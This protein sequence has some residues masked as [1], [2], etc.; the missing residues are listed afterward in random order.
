[1][2]A[3]LVFFSP[4]GTTRRVLESIAAGLGGIAGVLDMTLLFTDLVSSSGEAHLTGEDGG[5]SSPFL[6]VGPSMG[7]QFTKNARSV[8]PNTPKLRIGGDCSHQ[9][10][11]NP[12]PASPGA[13]P[14]R[15]KRE[16]VS[17]EPATF[18]PGLPVLVGAPVYAGRIPP[19]AAQRFLTLR[20]NDTPAIPVVVY[21]N[22]HYNDALLELADL[23]TSAGFVPVAGAA[24]IGE[25]PSPAQ[26]RPSRPEGLTSGTA[27]GPPSLAKRSDTNWPKYRMSGS[28]RLSNCPGIAPTS[29]SPEK[30][31]KPPRLWVRQCAR[32]AG[33]VSV[34]ALCVRFLRIT[35]LT[36]RSAF[37]A[38][39]ACEA[40]PRAPGALCTP[41]LGRSRE[42]SASAAGRERSLRPSSKA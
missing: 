24:F 6:R 36:S 20:G 19:A 40:A 41:G 1:M 28:C 13:P 11:E 30:C 21:G 9:Y 38:T 10:C 31:P 12:I 15:R 4:T 2:S 14:S 18:P 37:A 17:R 3:N 23:L 22:R 8:P 7:A 34:F 39:P 16:S 42:D 5:W 32:P 29:T 35:T 27:S 26:R 25:H 33:A